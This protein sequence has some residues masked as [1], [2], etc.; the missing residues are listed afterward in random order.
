MS[1]LLL[2]EERFAFRAKVRKKAHIPHQPMG[3][4]RPSCRQGGRL[5]ERAAGNVRRT[6]AKLRS[7]GAI[8]RTADGNYGSADRTDKQADRNHGQGDKVRFTT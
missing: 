7:S 8:S 6:V 2:S 5:D 3:K 4:K 1:F